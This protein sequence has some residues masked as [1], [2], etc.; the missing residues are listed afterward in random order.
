[1][2]V[3]KFFLISLRGMVEVSINAGSLWRGS[4][5]LGVVKSHDDCI[6]TDQLKTKRYPM[7]DNIAAV[8]RA[9]FDRFVVAGPLVSET[10]SKEC[11]CNMPRRSDKGTNDKLKKC[12][13][14]FRGEKFVLP[15]SLLNPP[16]EKT[17]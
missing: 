3:D 4:W 6:S 9:A 17:G 14:E 8:E 2:R 1:M 10:D 11:V 5:G 15:E 16:D 13:T 7:F 12:G